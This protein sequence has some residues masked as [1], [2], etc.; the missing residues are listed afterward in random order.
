M[1]GEAG[2]GGPDTTL[3]SPGQRG[4]SARGF[5]GHSTDT[6]ILDFWPPEP[7]DSRSV[8]GSRLCCRSLGRLT[9]SEREGHFSN[10]HLVESSRS[11]SV[12]PFTTF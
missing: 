9:E 1:T 7:Q 4:S 2:L 3:R 11:T 6:L 5:Q 8:R 12:T 10:A